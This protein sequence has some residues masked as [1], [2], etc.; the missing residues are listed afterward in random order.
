MKTAI[1]ATNSSNRS[2]LRPG[3]LPIPLLLFCFALIPIAQAQ[4]EFGRGNTAAVHGALES[5]T[6]GTH[7]T[8]L[9]AGDLHTLTTGDNN[10]ATGS[11]TLTQNT[12]N[13]N[14]ATSNP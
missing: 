9:G 11:Q 5:L 2:P 6:T 7:N 8:A 4:K 1:R 14:T 12:A 3:L 10:T 13:D